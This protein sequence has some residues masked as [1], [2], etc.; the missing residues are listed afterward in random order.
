MM[1]PDAAVALAERALAT[2]HPDAAYGFAAGSIVRG[3]ATAA[4]DLD[5]VVVYDAVKTGRRAS[6]TLDGTPV[7]TFIH[8]PETLA[9][10]LRDEARVAR[11]AMLNMVSEGRICGPRRSGAKSLQ[12]RARA[13][14]AQGP[15]PLDARRRDQLRYHITDKIDDLR[16]PRPVE[17]L[18]ALG[19]MLYDTLA[20]LI[21]RGAGRWAAN[22]KWIPR[23]LR[24]LDRA[25]GDAFVAAFDALLIRHDPAP[26][27]A[28]AETAL[29]PHGG[30]LFDGYE[31][32][33]PTTNRIARRRR[34]RN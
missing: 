12:S 2:R 18:P 33:W 1:T 8:D 25:M 6:F 23:S 3:E 31:N 24:A 21:L 17:Q 26:L 27:I 19:F 4:S 28:F 32:A 13:R 15:K 7:E 20:E 10:A 29:Q 30:W 22:G 11:C 16:D 9:W 14:L 5:L 34:F